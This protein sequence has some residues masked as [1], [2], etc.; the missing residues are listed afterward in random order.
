MT[1]LCLGNMMLEN[2]TALLPKY[3]EN[4]QEWEEPEF[5]PYQSTLILSI[6]AFA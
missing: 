4:E 2:M 5:Y 3:I 6:F 1:A